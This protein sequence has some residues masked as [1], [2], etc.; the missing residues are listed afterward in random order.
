MHFHRR[1]ALLRP[2]TTHPERA[3]AAE[4]RVDRVQELLAV[5]VQLVA[6]DVERALRPAAPQPNIFH[7]PAVRAVH[8]EARSIPLQSRKEFDELFKCISH[9]SLILI[10]T[11]IIKINI[12]KLYTP[13]CL[14]PP[15]PPP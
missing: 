7:F 10:Y 12:K 8:S 14:P 11:I 2:G 6:D 5:A 4:G 13:S 9:V 3:D 15:S 1:G